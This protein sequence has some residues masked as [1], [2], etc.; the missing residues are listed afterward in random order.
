MSS[1]GGFIDK[2]I[3]F[4]KKSEISLNYCQITENDDVN[5]FLNKTSIQLSITS[6][7]STV[8]CG[9][10]SNGQTDCW[11]IEFRDDDIWRAK[12]D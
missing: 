5:S 7:D 12:Q 10:I 4:W 2:V 11:R 6:I 3:V 9:R 1:F 8:F